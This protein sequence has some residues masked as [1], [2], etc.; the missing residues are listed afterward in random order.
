MIEPA[1]GT[2]LVP[3][4]GGTALL[5]TCFPAAGGAAVALTAITTRTDKEYRL[6]SL[7]AA[8]PLPENYFCLRLHPPTPADFDNGNRSW[9]GRSSFENGLLRKV[10]KPEPRCFQRRG[11]S[12]P[13][14]PQYNFSLKCFTADD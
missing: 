5:A 7:A 10:A 2:P 3:A 12:P 8:N 4:I 11:S 6:A 13:P 14:K 9:H 1:F